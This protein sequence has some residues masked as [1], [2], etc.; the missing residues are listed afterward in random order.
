MVCVTVIQKVMNYLKYNGTIS[1]TIKTDPERGGRVPSEF[2]NRLS[3][4]ITFYK[5]QRHQLEMIYSGNLRSLAKRLEESR[6]IK[7]VF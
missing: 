7:L 1:L 4:I 2:V 3:G 6:N 5:L